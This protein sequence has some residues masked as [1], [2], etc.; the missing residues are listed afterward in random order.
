MGPGSDVAARNNSEKGATGMRASAARVLGAGKW[1]PSSMW[2]LAN[3]GLWQ[4]GGAPPGPARLRPWCMRCQDLM[5]MALCMAWLMSWVYWMKALVRGRLGLGIRPST[6]RYLC[7]Q[8]KEGASPG[9]RVAGP[10]FEERG[11][12]PGCMHASMEGG[13]CRRSSG[14]PDPPPHQR[15]GR[16]PRRRS[17]H[18]G[19][20]VALFAAAH[21]KRRLAVVAVLLLAHVAHV[22]VLA[23]ELAT[24]DMEKH[25][26]PLLRAGLEGPWV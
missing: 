2:A 11:S 21:F 26:A 6:R 1:G 20:H 19:A 7:R 14:S 9:T 12:V 8:E 22:V 17:P 18:S 4:Q 10:W 3:A 24:H 5:L 25:E 15:P 23:M 13:A 16:Q